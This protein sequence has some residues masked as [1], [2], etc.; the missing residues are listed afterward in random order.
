MVRPA[1]AECRFFLSTLTGRSQNCDYNP[2]NDTDPNVEGLYLVRIQ[3]WIYPGNLLERSLQTTSVMISLE[4]LFGWGNFRPLADTSTSPAVRADRYIPVHPLH[5]DFTALFEP[6]AE[7]KPLRRDPR[8]CTSN[9]CSIGDQSDR[10]EM[11]GSDPV[12][13]ANDADAKSNNKDTHADS[14]LQQLNRQKNWK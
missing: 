2:N 8:L 1:C 6:L 11:D 13:L 3:T 5:C 9:H 4:D 10:S 12:V 7:D 14:A